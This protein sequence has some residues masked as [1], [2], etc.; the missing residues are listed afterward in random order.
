M[1]LPGSRTWYLVRH[2]ETAWNASGRMQGQLDS[3]LTARGREHASSSGRLLARLGV[4]AMFA[5]PLGRVRETLALVAEHVAVA[6]VFDDRLMEW[7]GGAWS[8]A[9]YADL[10]R[11]WP[12]EWAAWVADRYH[13]RA[14]GGEN[15]VDLA[16]RGR[17]F[18]EDACRAPGPRIAI[19]AHGYLNRALSQV[20]LGLSAAET[21]RIDQ[22]NDT[23]I[24]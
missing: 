7:S 22:G 23:V 11:R 9:L 3:A 18:L 10:P 17:S 1:S 13:Q 4:D 5:S 16:V 19:V 12:A 6:P 24:R 20:L 14:P 15:F 21:M 2:G 8:G